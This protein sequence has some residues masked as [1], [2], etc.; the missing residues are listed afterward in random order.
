MLRK[1]DHF[2][3][4]LGLIKVL[5]YPILKSGCY[6]NLRGE[7]RELS[8]VRPLLLINRVGLPDRICYNILKFLLGIQ[9]HLLISQLYVLCVVLNVIVPEA[10]RRSR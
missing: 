9:E 7:R 3:Q 6:K 2:I 5:R 4:C 10:S 8:A 1:Y